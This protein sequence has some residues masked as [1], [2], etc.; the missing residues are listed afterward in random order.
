MAQSYK[1]LEIYTLAHKLS[2]EV[3]RMTIEELP[4]F[5]QYEEGDQIRRSSKSIPVNIVEGFGR[6][7]YKDDFVRF[8]TFAHASCSET[9][10][11]LEILNDTGSLKRERFDYFFNKYD[12]LGRKLNSFIAAVKE[13]HRR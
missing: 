1:N 3:H 11:H 2:I 10:E 6:K 7:R 4:K 8:L 9:I 12:L 5:E 13:G